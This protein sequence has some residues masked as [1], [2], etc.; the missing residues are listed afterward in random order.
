MKNCLRPKLGFAISMMI[1]SCVSMLHAQKLSGRV[2][3]SKNHEPLSKAAVYF[4]ELHKGTSTNEDG[5]FTIMGLGQQKMLIQISHVGYEIFF[6]SLS[7]NRDTTI[8][9]FLSPSLIEMKEVVVTGRQSQDVNETSFNVAQVSAR[10]MNS[11]GSLSISDAMSRLPGISQLTTGAGIS[12]PVIRGLYGNRIQVNVNGMRFDNQQWQD[13]HGLGLSDIGV[14]RVEIIKGP[15]SVLYGSDAIGGVMNVIEEKPAPTGEKIQELNTRI[16]SNTYG[17]SANYGI[18]KTTEKNWWRIRAGFDN[19]ADYTAGNNNRVL[20]SRFASYNLKA[21]L[22]FTK[23]NMVSVNNVFVSY[24]KFGF[25]FDSLSR[26]EEDG[27]LSRSFDGP[28]H[29][30]VFAQASTENTFYKGKRKAKLNGGLITNLRQE[31]EGGG[32]ISLS[33]LLNTASILGQFTHQISESSELTYGASSYFQTNT[34]F[35]GRIIVP[36]AVTAELSAFSFFHHKRNQILFEGGVRYDRRFIGTQAT[37]SLNVIGAGL[38]PTQDVLPFNKFYNAFN[39]STGTGYD[40]TKRLSFKLNASTGYRPGNLAELSSNGLHEGTLRWEIGKPDAKTEHNLNLEGSLLYNHPTLRASI[41]A[42][43]NRFWNYIFLNP[44][45]SEFFG[46]GIYRYEQ[47]DA[48]LEGGEI[49]VNWNAFNSPIEIVSAYSFIKAKKE[50]GTYLPFIPANKL[51]SEVKFHLKSGLKFSNSILRVGGNYVFQQNHPAEFE[52]STADYFLIN[53]GVTT[54][55][56]KMNLSF[57]CNNLLN[58]TYYDHLSRF[59]YYGIANMGRN[60]VMAINYKF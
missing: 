48:A 5:V 59:K 41:S 44:T 47:S 54:D 51:N 40:F 18:K 8:E 43:R 49:N 23:R 3:D 36:N 34:N 24:S 20:N 38:S 25:V 13:E 56:R 11:Q 19:H 9:V 21:S 6:T 33:M 55:W 37:G 50:D 32:G 53:A 42:Y 12:K 22:G 14:D 30:V 17:L 16:F 58:K 45:G 57:T 2:V 28:H 46:F 4:P 60:V 39:F 26:K 1:F 15:S 10:E 35:G 31:D 7:F 29:Q 52:T 27:R